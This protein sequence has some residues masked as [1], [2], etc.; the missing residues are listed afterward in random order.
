MKIKVVNVI[1]EDFS[2]YKRASMTIGFPFCTF[3]CGRQVCQNGT[4][5]AAPKI[6]I[7]AADLVERYMKNPIT[8][9]I[10]F[11]GLEPFDSPEVFDLVAEFRTGTETHVDAA[12]VVGFEVFL[13][14]YSLGRNSRAERTQISQIDRATATDS[15]VHLLLQSRKNGLD[16][17]TSHGT[18][19]RNVFNKFIQL[20][21]CVRL[22]LTIKENDIGKHVFTGNYFVL[23][24][25]FEMF[26]R[27]NNC[28]TAEEP[29]R[30]RISL[31]PLP[32]K[33][34]F[35]VEI[36]HVFI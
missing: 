22:D 10:I 15:L 29:A 21:G 19:L 6:E 16:I 20:D 13:V 18:F 11:Q 7:E 25:S 28:G 5:A 26:L 12:N 33:F 34:I 31:L 9:A 2:N 36:F 24:H 14:L 8:E 23:K 27:V 35:L 3:K 1:D 17:V 4:L 32:D 30:F